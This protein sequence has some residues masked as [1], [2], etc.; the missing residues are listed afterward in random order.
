ME[1]VIFDLVHV[2]LTSFSA[3]HTMIGAR[4]CS[5]RHSVPIGILLNTRRTV[6]GTSLKH[7]S[8]LTLAVLCSNWFR[9]VSIP[10]T[11]CCSC[12]VSIETKQYH[13]ELAFFYPPIHLRATRT[14]GQLLFPGFS[15]KL[16]SSVHCCSV[17]R[18]HENRKPP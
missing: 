5:T 9:L 16:R 18:K 6:L 8:N 3:E 17:S 13:L 7:G 1:T 2:S 12:S 14:R 10:Q 4:S 15:I 11:D